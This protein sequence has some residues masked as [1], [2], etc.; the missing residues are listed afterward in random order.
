MM[1]GTVS[2]SLLAMLTIQV[3]GEEG[4]T[5]TVEAIVDTGYNGYITLPP[6]VLQSLSALPLPDKGIATLADGSEVETTAYLVRVVWDGTEK[7]VTADEAVGIPLIGMEL[8]LD[9]VVTVEAWNGGQV[10]LTA[11]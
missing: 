1:N 5:E 8:M 9:Y 3:K 6:F 4:Q 7:I 10:I 2:A 11:R